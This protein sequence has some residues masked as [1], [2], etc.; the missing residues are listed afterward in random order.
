LFRRRTL[1]KTMGWA[2]NTRPAF[3]ERHVRH[4]CNSAAVSLGSYPNV[5][6]HSLTLQ[7]LQAGAAFNS[8]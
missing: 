7:K 4:P 1:S 3:I 6:P 2:D 8:F 5:I